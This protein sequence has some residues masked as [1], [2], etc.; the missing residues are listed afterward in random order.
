MLGILTP[1][2]MDL[3][4][5]GGDKVFAKIHRGAVLFHGP[6]QET[7]PDLV[8]ILSKSFDVP[9]SFRRDVRATELIVPNRH[10]LRDGGHEPEGIF[11]L[12]GPNQRA[13]GRLPSQPIVAIAPTILEIFGLPIADDID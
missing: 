4:T 5:P 11:L 13:A 12:R 6:H 9:A 2:L 8:G 1:E 3:K 10:I 7:A